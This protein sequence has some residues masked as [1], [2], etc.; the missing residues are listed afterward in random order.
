MT[1]RIVSMLNKPIMWSRTPER[2]RTR[3]DDAGSNSGGI[4][5][6]PWMITLIISLFSGF[7]TVAVIWGTMSARLDAIDARINRLER[8]TDADRERERTRSPANYISPPLGTFVRP[9]GL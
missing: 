4:T 9:A 1:T 6:Q 3:D 5:L 8:I 7:I 2:E